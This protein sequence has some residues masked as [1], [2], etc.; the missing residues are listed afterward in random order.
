MGVWE[1]FLWHINIKMWMFN[2]C[3]LRSRVF[4]PIAWM[5][6][7][8]ACNICV[9]IISLLILLSVFFLWTRRTSIELYWAIGT[10]YIIKKKTVQN[11]YDIAISNSKIYFPLWPSPSTDLLILWP[12][13]IFWSQFI[14]LD[15]HVLLIY[16]W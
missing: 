4:R 12:T 3:N 7:R 14:S 6:L 8:L 10:H 13:A 5:W 16:F 9:R 15:I 2:N 11:V 1:F